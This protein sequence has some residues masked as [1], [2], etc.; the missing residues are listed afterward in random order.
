M[1]EVECQEFLML[2]FP[3]HLN[4]GELSEERYGEAMVAKLDPVLIPL[5]RSE[6][7][8]EGSE[9]AFF[10]FFVGEMPQC[11]VN[12]DIRGMSGSPIFGFRREVDGNY[13]YWIVAL[14]SRRSNAQRE[15]ILACPLQ[16]FA[17]IVERAMTHPSEDRSES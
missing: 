16:I 4:G 3:A 8:P 10:P 9:P 13:R 12:F 1:P 2:G 14:Q 5:R 15:V 7:L 17:P 11:S 6:D